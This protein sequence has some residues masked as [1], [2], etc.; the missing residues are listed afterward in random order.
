V[1]LAVGIGVAG[2][3][4]TNRLLASQLFEVDAADPATLGAGVAA[5]C[6][7][8]LLACYVPARRAMQVEPLT[9]LRQD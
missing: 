6:A 9:A 5:L 1:A 7:L 2:A 8:A 3:L 4:A